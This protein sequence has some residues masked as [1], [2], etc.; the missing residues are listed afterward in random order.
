MTIVPGDLTRKHCSNPVLIPA[1]VHIATTNLKESGDKSPH[2]KE[3]SLV[4]GLVQLS[5]PEEVIHQRHLQWSIGRQTDVINV[6]CQTAG[7]DLVNPL[8]HRR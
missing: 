2:S 1:C 4:Q 8:A 5:A 7:V 6:A 3:T